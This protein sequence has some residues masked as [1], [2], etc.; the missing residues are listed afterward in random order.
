MNGKLST[1]TEIAD[2]MGVAYWRVGY[3]IRSSRVIRDSM[4]KVGNTPAW[5]A[6]GCRRIAT[7]IEKIDARRR[8]RVTA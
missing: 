3:V 7:A 2:A 6:A 8:D 4:V 5:D 1:I